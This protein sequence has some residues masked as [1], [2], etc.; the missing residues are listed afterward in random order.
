MIAADGAG[1]GAATEDAAPR[2]RTLVVG[3]GVAGSTVALSLADRGVG[4]VLV[5]R[6]TAGAATSASAGMLAA[7]WEA[8]EPDALFHLGRRGQELHPGFAERIEELSGENPGLSRAGMLVANRDAD[9]ER[10]ARETARRQRSEGLR[11]RIVDPSEATGLQA[12]LAPS[13]IS[14]LWLPDEGWLDAQR[15]GATL[16]SALAGAGVEL[17][18][19]T[20]ERVRIDGRAATGVELRSGATVTAGRIVLATGAWTGR[21]DGL[22]RR[23][24]VRPVRGQMLRYAAGDVELSRIVS[25]HGGRYVVPRPD[26][27][28]I[29][30]S[31]MEDAGFEPRVTEAGRRSIRTAAEELIPA[32]AEADVIEAWAGLRPVTPDGLPILGPDPEVEGLFY[33]TGY[34]RNGIL[35]APAAAEL[36]AD[37]VTDRT[38]EIDGRPFALERFEAGGESKELDRTEER[39]GT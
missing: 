27:S 23:V 29:A 31:T 2:E 34:G 24:P 32:L 13:A 7:Q 25:N 36:V 14:W 18:D 28:A 12:G 3:G 9:E 22:P 16:P 26:G 20:V 19:G 10:A 6:P 1:A 39:G 4:V 21:L 15:L 11:A 8:S 38:P 17:V 33:A 35:V 30:G 37:L 5:D